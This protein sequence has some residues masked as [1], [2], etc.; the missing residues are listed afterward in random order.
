MH[1]DNPFLGIQCGGRLEDR[2]EDLSEDH[3]TTSTEGHA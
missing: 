2:P 3:R 1:D